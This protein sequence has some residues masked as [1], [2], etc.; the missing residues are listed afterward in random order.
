MERAVV[1]AARSI[2]IQEKDVM[3][4]QTSGKRHRYEFVHAEDADFVAYQ[5]DTGN[6]RWQTLSTWMIPRA[7]LR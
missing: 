7:D 4:K 3:S 5:R 2:V 1:L 6:G